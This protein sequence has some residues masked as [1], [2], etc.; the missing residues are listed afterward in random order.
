MSLL[1]YQAIHRWTTAW[2]MI[3]NKNL[4]MHEYDFHLIFEILTTEKTSVIK[5]MNQMSVIDIA[6]IWVTNVVDDL[7]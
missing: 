2:F 5:I 7:S 3:M 1:N 6:M 4:D